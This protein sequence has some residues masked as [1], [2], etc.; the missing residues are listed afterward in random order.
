[1]ASRAIVPNE[2]PRGENNKQKN[3]AAEGRNRRVLQD[4]GNLVAKQAEPGGANVSKRNTRNFRSQLL[5]N[6]QAAAE[7]NKKSSTE[8]VNGAVV[9]AANG[10]SVANFIAA[11]KVEQAQK[12]TEPEV[13]VISSDE[14]CE[15]KKEK[16]QVVKGRTTRARSAMKNAKAFS[17]VLTAR[18][19]AACGLAYKPKDLVE[20]IDA[21]D[22][23]NELAA[24]EY[25]DEIY[26]YYKLT[27]ED[28]CV[29]DYMGSQPDVNAK[30]RSILMDWLIEVHRKFELMPETLYLTINIVDRFL[31]MKTVPRKELQLVGIS[32]MLIA[33]KYEEI[34]APEVNDFV[35]I[36]DNAYVREQ[37][38][39]M[40]KTIL[41]NLEWYLT[42]PTPYVFLLRYIKASTPSDK[43]MESMVFFLAELSLMHYPTVTLYCPSVIAAS[44]VYA[45]RCTL[46]RSPF[47][48]ETLKHYT[49]YSEEQLRDCAKLMVN[50]HSDAPES[51][52][53]AVYKKF[54]SPDRCAVALLTPAKN[55]SAQS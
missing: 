7:K 38:L 22:D 51:K 18:S 32:S 55:F 12:P 5:A 52:L 16:K 1:M 11:T 9:A 35:C 24:V 14:D 43:E 46:E 34:W 40:E 25:I 42:V 50:L 37:V 20:N 21:T 3:V 45:G 44:A 17:S 53:R 54:C 49:S 13:I 36:S 28:G 10:V 47:W 27:E 41:G 33:S 29:H 19:K 23:D 26:K 8:L 4:I 39:L 48:T 15:E 31:S 30:M 2:Q 6:G